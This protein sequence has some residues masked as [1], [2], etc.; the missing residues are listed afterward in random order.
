MRIRGRKAEN[1]GKK[2]HGGSWRRSQNP[3]P[4]ES[5]GAAPGLKIEAIILP[6]D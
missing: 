2:E 5:K 4:Q 3:H 1:L 6:D